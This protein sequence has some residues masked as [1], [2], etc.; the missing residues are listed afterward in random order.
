M[1][2]SVMITDTVKLGKNVIIESHCMI[3]V[4]P[5]GYEAS[6]LQTII[7]DNALIRSHTIIY[8]GNRIGTNFQTG[9]HVVIREKNNIGDNVCIGTL[10]CIEHHITI[11]DDVRI[12]SQVFVPEF[13]VLKKECW[14]GPNAVL[15]NA[16]Y[17]H[18]R[19][20]KKTLHGPIIE[21]KAKIGANA[22][23]L[24]SIRIGR[25][26]LVGAGS[27]VTKDVKPYGVVAGNPAKHI[28]DTREI[29]EYNRERKV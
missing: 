10:S 17:P 13:S 7:G 27:V 15:I 25:E 29:N 1:V 6:G 12:H 8:A 24:P 21:E 22:T 28:G 2:N 16:K 11:E 3:G 5:H 19:D 23:I 4:I 26:A 14:I 9:H 20:A 18:C